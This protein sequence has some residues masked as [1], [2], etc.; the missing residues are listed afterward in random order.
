MVASGGGGAC[1]PFAPPP[2]GSGTDY[3]N[4]IN[5]NSN[6]IIIPW[7][8]TTYI[9]PFFPRMSECFSMLLKQ[10]HTA[11]LIFFFRKK[12]GGVYA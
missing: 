3:Y 12:Y 5:D 7:E 8:I 2:L 11:Q 6:K 4:N 1:A 10:I 9:S